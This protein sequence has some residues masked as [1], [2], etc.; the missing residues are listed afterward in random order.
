METGRGWTAVCPHWAHAPA[1]IYVIAA[2]CMAKHLGTLRL[3]AGAAGAA[4]PCLS[5]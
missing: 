2:D 5:V 3:A 4:V 1:D